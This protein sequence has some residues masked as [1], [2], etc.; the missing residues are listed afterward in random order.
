MA[1]LVG[2]VAVMGLL[3]RLGDDGSRV[4]LQVVKTRRKHELEQTSDEHVTAGATV[5][6][7]ALRS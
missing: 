5:Y 4:R 1:T 7:D 3:Q 2:R 6:S